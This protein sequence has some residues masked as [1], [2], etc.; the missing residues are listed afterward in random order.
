MMRTLL[1]AVVGL[2]VLIQ[3][4]LADDKSAVENL[5]NSKLDAAVEILQQKN[6]AKQTKQAK[7]VEIVTPMFDFQLM[8]KLT[9]GRKYW[10]G[11]AREDKIKF[12]ELFFKL[13]KRAYL[14]ELTTY[15]DEEIIVMSPLEIKGKIHIPTYLVSEDSQILML[16]KFYQRN[17]IWKVYDIEIQ[18]VSIIQSYRIQFDEILQKRTFDDLLQKL[19]QLV[20]Q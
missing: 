11:L 6:L 4:V 7:I 18:G 19:E 14:N 5:L 15:T 12:T 17:N 16:Y 2:L 3:L 20:N 10:P 8:A 13:L 1:Y 9:L